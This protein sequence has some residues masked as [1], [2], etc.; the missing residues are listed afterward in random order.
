MNPLLSL[1]MIVK[2]EESV[3]RRCL[4]SVQG[5]VD[6]IIIVDTGSTDRTKKIAAEFTD[7]V[8]DFTWINDFSAA[9][10]EAL[11]H[12]SGCWILVLDA[13]EY[14]SKEQH[15]EVRDRLAAE[16]ANPS[17]INAF[18]LPIYNLNGSLHNQNWQESRTVR[19]FRNSPDI[20]YERP[21][22][23]QVC[24]KNGMMLMDYLTLNIFHTGYTAETFIAKNK[25]ERN[26][27]LFEE[28]RKQ[29]DFTEY[30]YFTLG[31]EHRNQKDYTKALYYYKRAVTK[32]SYN[33]IFLPTCLVN[34]ALLLIQLD[35]VKEALETIE[36]GI[37]RWS[38]RVD[39]YCLKA[40]LLEKAG[41]L[42]QAADYYKRCIQLAEQNARQNKDYWL[43]EPDYGSRIPALSLSRIYAYS[44]DVQ[45]ETRYLS[46]LVNM[47]KTNLQA[48]VALIRLLLLT[49]EHA[50][51][52]NYLDRLYADPSPLQTLTL[53]HAAFLL[54]DRAL[55]DLYYARC[56]EADIP[57]TAFHRLSYALLRHDKE[58]F[59]RALEAG[60]GEKE[61]QAINRLI[62]LSVFLWQD[63]GF[64]DYLRADDS[65]EASLLA[66][67]INTL[68]YILGQALEQDMICDLTIVADTLVQLFNLGDYEAYDSIIRK[69][70]EAEDALT[71]LMGDRFFTQWQIQ[72]AFDYYAN[73][74]KRNSLA[75]Q[76]NENLACYYLAHGEREEGLEFLAQAIKSSPS[77]PPLYPLYLKHCPEPDAYQAMLKQYQRQLPQYAALL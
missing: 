58:Q 74:L 65:Q 66:R 54:G 22:H 52:V 1:C 28:L 27:K 15:A 57:L 75:S 23:E 43:T 60:W 7:K 3:L 34:M 14:L 36:S 29:R 48:L 63:A 11:R 73:A 6:E 62:V 26:L 69:F 12:A 45:N 38:S 68:H 31:N 59:C 5:F 25:S 35:R 17:G 76:G 18:L 8:Y 71:N 40:S 16:E 56:Q 47:N 9:R 39:F 70:S 55:G 67:Q 30:D 46:M 24:H 61:V 72:L 64:M 10:N 13:D 77:R 42:D 41:H 21:I 4:E 50:A 37:N 2:D 49:D 53:L 32:R 19:L 51:V 44:C 33:Y 20:R